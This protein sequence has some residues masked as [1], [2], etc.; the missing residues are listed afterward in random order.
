MASYEVEVN[1]ERLHKKESQEGFAVY[2]DRGLMCMLQV[3]C[4]DP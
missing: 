1:F 2:V 3:T 4:L